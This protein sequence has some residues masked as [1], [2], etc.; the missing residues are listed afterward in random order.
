MKLKEVKYAN[1]I[2]E[3]AEALN[4]P[5]DID[6]AMDAEIGSS[7][8]LKRSPNPRLICFWSRS[9]AAGKLLQFLHRSGVHD[10]R[11]NAEDRCGKQ[12]KNSRNIICSKV[13][14]EEFGEVKE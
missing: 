3:Y 4:Y 7:D 13:I 8:F 10:L 9:G 5:S 6:E 14:E 2:M 1:E 12:N 11:K